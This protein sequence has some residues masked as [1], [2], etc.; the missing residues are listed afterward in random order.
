[1]ASRDEGW[2][3][4][5]SHGESGQSYG[6]SGRR[7]A[8]RGDGWQVGVTDGESGRRMAI[9]GEGWRRVGSH[10]ESGRRMARCSEGWDALRDSKAYKLSAGD[11]NALPYRCTSRRD[12]APRCIGAKTNAV[13]VSPMPRMSRHSSP[14]YIS[15]NRI[16]P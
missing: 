11:I 15:Q 14:K 1:M 9:R 5:G 12:I 4:V 8:S 10:G 13:R 3:R 7:M 6:E 2:R 16:H